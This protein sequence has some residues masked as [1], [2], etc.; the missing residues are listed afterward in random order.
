MVSCSGE[1]N[2]CVS[3]NQY[4]VYYEMSFCFIG[5][6]GGHLITYQYLITCII[7]IIMEEYARLLIIIIIIG[8]C[9]P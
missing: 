4:D 8:I 1:D 6:H 3:S 2:P 5:L 7:I 9:K